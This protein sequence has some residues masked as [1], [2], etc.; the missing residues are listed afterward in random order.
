MKGVQE[1]MPVLERFIH[2]V[3]SVHTSRSQRVNDASNVLS[4]YAEGNNP[5]DLLSTGHVLFQYTKRVDYKDG[6]CGEQCF[7]WVISRES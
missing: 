4:I 6:H 5:W 1:T 3:M 2:G 7:E